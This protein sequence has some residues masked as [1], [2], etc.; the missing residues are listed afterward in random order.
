MSK[1]VKRK[2]ECLHKRCRYLQKCAIY[3]G[4]DCIHQGGTR[5]PRFI[6]RG[7]P[8]RKVA[9]AGPGPD[10]EVEIVMSAGFLKAGGWYR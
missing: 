7:R 3:W 10:G 1:D 8:G 9:E 5:P 6:E 4:K 2:L